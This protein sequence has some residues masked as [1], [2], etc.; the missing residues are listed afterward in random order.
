VSEADISPGGI[1]AIIDSIHQ[2]LDGFEPDSAL[3]I[4]GFLSGFESLYTELGGALLRLGDRLGSDY[5]IDR[6]VVE[7]LHDMGAHTLTLGAWGAQTHH[8][9]R[10]AHET[11]IQRI[12]QPRPREGMWDVD[13]YN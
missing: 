6:S 13:R 7:H 11:E 4:L 8:L 2:H 3:A 10:A 12:E 1:T 9:A 5:P